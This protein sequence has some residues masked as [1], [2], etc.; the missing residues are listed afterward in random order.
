MNTTYRSK[1][2]VTR[3]MARCC[4]GVAKVYPRCT[5]ALAILMSKLRSSLGAAW[6]Q[7][8][9]SLEYAYS[10]LMTTFLRPFSSKR[11]ELERRLAANEITARP[12]RDYGSSLTRLRLVVSLLLMLT[13]GSSSV[14][15]QDYSGTYY[16]GNYNNKGYNV[17]TPANNY[18]LVPAANP[19]QTHQID[20]YYSANYGNEDGDSNQ[21]F[22]TTYKTN[23]DANSVWILEASGESGFYYIKHQSTGRYV[24]YEPVF[25]GDNSRRKS[26]HLTTGA[27]DD[28]AKFEISVS[29]PGYAIRP[30]SVSSGHRF[31]NAAG[32]NT[33]N[34]YGDSPTS[35]TA[36]YYNGLVGL[37]SDAADKNGIWYLEIPKP[38]ISQDPTTLKISMSCDLT[39]VAI[40]YTTDG[41]EPTKDSPLY[42]GE[43][44]PEIG[45][46]VFK[47]KALNSSGDIASAM[48]TFELTKNAAP[49]IS[50]NWNDK[51]VTISSTV[52][53]GT[54]FYTTNGNNPTVSSTVYSGPISFS[55]PTTFKAIVGKVGYA[56]STVT[57]RDV[58]KV[59]T[60]TI[61]DNGNVAIAITTATV[62]ASI[63]YTTD[64][65][66]PTRSSSPYSAPLTNMEGKTIKAIAVKAN[67]YDSDVAT[68]GPVSFSCAQP[69]IR[70]TGADKFTITCSKP[71]SGVTIYYTINGSTPSTSDSHVASGEA[72]TFDTSLLP[73]TVKAIAV[74][75]GFLNSSEASLT[76]SDGGLSGSGTPADPYQIALNSDYSIFAT[77]VNTG[78]EASACY[79]VTGDINASGVA[80]ITTPFTG[81]FD[82]NGYTISNLGHALFN[83]VSGGTVKNVILDA[84]GISSGTNV[85][86]I[87][88]EAIG[89][90][91]NKASIYNCGVLSGSISGSG[92]VGSIVGKLGDDS[93]NDNSYARVINCY[94]YATIGGGSSVGGIVGYNSFASV[95]NNLRTMVMNCMYYGKITGGSNKAP[96]YN[97]QNI[98]NVGTN[99]LANYNYYFSC[100]C[101]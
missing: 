38:V 98:T 6:E 18:Y 39:G 90:S 51:Q 82:G 34:Y 59:V 78:G 72:V 25:S 76:I 83:T 36:T 62:G 33:D 100:A 10:M 44:L 11:A 9:G 61:Y 85:G 8:G 47:A 60:P 7:P 28:K 45:T 13:L 19:Q 16:I 66:T 58:I 57:T 2:R 88:N 94:S 4:Q 43:F 64:G 48:T 67:N 55:K 53:G 96:I 79:I 37:Y 73:F 87:A 27:L 92:Y 26:V 63:Y 70:R 74:A 71:Q 20:A 32:G 56:P 22:L 29:K 15:G 75:D 69:I 91:A 52:E 35:G 99:G 68:F 86:S 95:A 80:E 89:T 84:V 77:K 81:T 97:G 41:K 54:I 23:K 93:N 46:S 5:Q 31:F 17:E 101:C 24:I 14:W 3:M 1:K 50:L 42:E 30:K 21:P 12:S 40:R 49:T 65:S